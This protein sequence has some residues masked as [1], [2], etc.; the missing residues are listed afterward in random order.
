MSKWVN[1]LKKMRKNWG[2]P[3]WLR[4]GRPKCKL[5]SQIEKNRKSHNVVWCEDNELVRTL[6]HPGKHYQ[7]TINGFESA[8]SN[9]FE[10]TML[11]MQKLVDTIFGYL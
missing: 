8:Q 4:S 3:C 2:S 1:H 10:M 6:K 11:S 7:C 9:K 5:P